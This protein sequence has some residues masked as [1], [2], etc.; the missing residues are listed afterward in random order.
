M[1]F[2]SEYLPL[3]EF[4]QGNCIE[5]TAGKY[6]RSPVFELNLFISFQKFIQAYEF[7][8]R[9]GFFKPIRFS[10]TL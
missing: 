8:C 9:F 7:L 5:C 2:V 6:K 1:V 10:E 3:S 4:M